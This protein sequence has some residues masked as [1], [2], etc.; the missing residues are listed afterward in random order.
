MTRP[1]AERGETV[2]ASIAAA[3]RSGALSAREI[4]E[5]VRI[6]E[7]EVGDH[8]AHLEKS[9]RA[10][11]E[12]LVIEPAACLTCGFVFEARLRHGRPSR[13]PECKGERLSVPRFRIA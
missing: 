11:S 1:P 7:R 9:L 12:R 10:Q 5:Q 3:L 4:S 13:C 8:L 6:A 2:R